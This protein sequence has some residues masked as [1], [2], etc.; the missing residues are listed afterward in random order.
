MNIKLKLALQFTLLVS[1]ILVFFAALIYYFFYD[2]QLHKF[3]DGLTDTAKN[4]AVLLI[5]VVEVDS[6]L[7][8]KIQQ[9]TTSWEE[10]EIVLT[11]T[12]F[13][14]VYSKNPEY[15]TTNELKA[16]YPGSAV[17]YFTIM[18][19]DGIFYKHHFKGKTYYVYA[20]AFDKSRR[21]NLAELRAI[22]VWG[23]LISIVLSVYISYVFSR[24]A[25]LPIVRLIESI[26]AINS[27][28]LD[29]RLHEGNRKDEIA[30]LAISFNKMLTDIEQSFRNQEDFVS[31]ASHELRTPLSIML[32]ESEYLLTRERTTDEYMK[33][34]EG[35]MEDVINLNSMLNSLLELA[36][37]NR[38]ITI[39]FTDIPIDEVVF[40]AI[41]LVK[42]KYNDRRIVPRIVYPEPDTSLLI[43]GNA[44]LLSIAFKNLLEN[45]CKFSEDEVLVEFT[46]DSNTIKVAVTDQGIGIPAGQLNEIFSPFRRGSNARFKSGFG[47]GLSLV[48]RIMEI[49]GVPISIQ[50]LE[51]KGTTM[52]LTFKRIKFSN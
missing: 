29:D 43:R 9:S 17:H 28:K 5:D 30:Q 36:H 11:D 14:V 21:E 49:H 23:I 13:G 2:S 1:I 51:H 24:R 31:H 47:L 37:L 12:L 39:Q 25:I 41:Q 20:A 15:L 16:H 50:T 26:N 4:T 46:I 10:E 7:L 40:N 52:E 18:E 34:I 42:T 27:S 44:G 33:H 48:A 19:K 3:R 32:M 45:A 22:L 38:E 35:Q 6:A 8:Q